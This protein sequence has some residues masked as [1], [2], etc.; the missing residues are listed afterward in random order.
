MSEWIK[1]VAEEDFHKCNTM[2][3]MMAFIDAYLLQTLKDQQLKD[4]EFE[5]IE[6]K[7]IEDKK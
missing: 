6:P 7:Q 5:V 1:R 4:A 3:E 2:E